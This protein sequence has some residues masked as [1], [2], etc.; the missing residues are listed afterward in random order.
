MSDP[1]TPLT[2]ASEIEAQDR[3]LG[4]IGAHVKHEDVATVVAALRLAEADCTRDDE[5][6]RY[7]GPLDTNHF[8]RAHELYRDALAAYRLARGRAS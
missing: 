2:L 1:V 8:Q 5:A 7:V 6:K 4:G 3:D